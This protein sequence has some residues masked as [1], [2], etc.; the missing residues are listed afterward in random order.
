MNGRVGASRRSIC[1][2][3]ITFLYL[4][5]PYWGLRSAGNSLKPVDT[6]TAP[7]STSR[8]WSRAC[9]SMQSSTGQASTHSPHS[10]QTPQ[11]RQRPAAVAGLG[12]GQRRLDLAEVVRRGVMTSPGARGRASA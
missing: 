10:E 12:L 9:R 5:K 2:P 6:T 8:T 3:V 7:T 4:P 1:I 11:S